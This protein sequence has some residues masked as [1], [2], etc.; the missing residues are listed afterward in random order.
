MITKCHYNNCWLHIIREWV[1][2]CSNKEN[3]SIDIVQH[4]SSDEV[5]CRIHHVI[6]SMTTIDLI[7][8]LGQAFWSWWPHFLNSPL[9]HCKAVHC[10]YFSQFYL[11]Y[12]L[13]RIRCANVA[14]FAS[15]FSRL[16]HKMRRRPSF[17]SGW[18]DPDNSARW[19]VTIA[20][21][22]RSVDPSIVHFVVKAWHFAHWFC[23]Q[24]Q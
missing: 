23:R 24:K 20:I 9:S 18:S 12:C 10:I 11:C 3:I 4:G 16:T 5:N 21:P 7:I 13:V 6:A 17:R 2:R 8:N 1:G 14:V 15:L 19:L 22:H